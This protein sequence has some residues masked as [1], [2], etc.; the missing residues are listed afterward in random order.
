MMRDRKIDKVTATPEEIEALFGI[1]R[2]TLGNLRWQKRGPRYFKVGLR[3]VL[4][5]LDDV[6]SWI[7]RNPIL[8]SDC[9]DS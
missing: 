4:Y 9:I 3:R 8:T 6:R 2:G 5:K 1:P 7:E